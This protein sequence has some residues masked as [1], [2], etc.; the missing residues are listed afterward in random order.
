MKIRNFRQRITGQIQFNTINSIIRWTI[1]FR[2]ASIKPLEP[3]STIK[4]LSLQRMKQL[5]LFGHST[6][7]SRL[8]TLHLLK[9]FDRKS[10][11]AISRNSLG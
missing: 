5:H 4:V 8:F 11:M 7:E 3:E 6:P 1:G 9:V 2:G 10:V